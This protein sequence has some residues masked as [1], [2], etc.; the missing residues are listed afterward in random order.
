M[1]TGTIVIVFACLLS[2]SPASAGTLQYRTYVTPLS[3]ET[4]AGNCIYQ[5]TIPDAESPVRAVFVIFERGWQVGNV[6]YDPEVFRFAERHH[7]ALLLAQHCPMKGSQ[8]IDVVPEHG[9][10]RALLT[11]LEQFAGTSKHSE[12]A[13]SKLILFSFSGGGSLVAR[14]VTYSADRTLAAIEYAPG[15]YDPVGIDT[16]GFTSKSLQVPQLIIANGA[17]DRCGTAQPYAYFASAQKAGAPVTLVIQNQAPHCCVSNIVPLV[18]DWLDPV[19]Q[20]REPKSGNL[21]LNPINTHNG[22]VGIIKVRDSG[23]EESN[24]SHRKVWNAESAEISSAASYRDD[25]ENGGIAVPRTPKD[26]E[27]PATGTLIPSWLPSRDFAEAWL[28]FE[29]E[30]QHPI[31]PLE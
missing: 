29:Q 26:A 19:L 31:T 27:I 13:T 3:G 12:V 24:S 20:M 4:L 15:H 18:L 9:I 30:R 2:V 17:D 7:I 28:S 6:Y 8:D 25:A 1:H 11:A 23:V 14:M 5:M 16:V 21:P 22:W 10:G